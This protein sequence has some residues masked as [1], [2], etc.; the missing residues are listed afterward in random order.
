MTG[1]LL[2]M[3]TEEGLQEFRRRLDILY[4]VDEITLKF[5]RDELQY[6]LLLLT[7]VMEDDDPDDAEIS[8]IIRNNILNQIHR[9]TENEVNQ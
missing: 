9:F 5:S 8:R 4:S 1:E 6:L 2:N 3:P 7:N